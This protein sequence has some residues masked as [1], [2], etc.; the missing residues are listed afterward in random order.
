[1]KPTVY[2]YLPEADVF[3]EM[4]MNLDEPWPVHLQ[5]G[6]YFWIHKTY[7]LLSQVGYPCEL[8]HRIP[9]SGI[10]VAISFQIPRLPNAEQLFV[11]VKADFPHSLFA[12][13]H[14]IQNPYD[15]IGLKDRLF[16]RIAYIPHWPE[17]ALISREPGRAETFEN[18]VYYGALEN[19][20]QELQTDDWRD[21]LKSRDL[22][23]HHAKAGAW[24]DYS[25]ADATVSIRDFNGEA[26]NDK[27]AA[28]LVNSWIA[29]VPAI[30]T[31]E[32]A[33]RHLRR[34]PH[35]YCEVR[36]YGE[37]KDTIV[38]L[39]GDPGLR[40]QMVENGKRRAMEFTIPAITSQWIKFIDSQAIPLW[41]R[42]VS[43][44]RL[45]RSWYIETRRR[46]LRSFL[47]RSARKACTIREWPSL[48][49]RLVPRPTR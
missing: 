3:A 40:G 45:R 15:N 34:G 12:Q 7:L 33:Y 6:R 35:D 48:L 37:L 17:T 28:K 38:T 36:T 19:L 46:C 32:S 41:D 9:E 27:P 30:V 14:V 2:F 5:L 26:W 10:V 39:Q 22:V 1:M 44:S 4:P 18:L 29:G 31:P 43:D 42:W 20:A 21:F 23:F 13:I 11:G 16:R 47:R 8:I 24:H 49:R 25:Y